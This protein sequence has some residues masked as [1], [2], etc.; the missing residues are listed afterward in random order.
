M[1][2]ATVKSKPVMVVGVVR[3]RAQDV[4]SIT[5]EWD[6]DPAQEG[7]VPTIDGSELLTDGKRHPGTSRTQNWVKIGKKQD[8]QKHAYGITILKGTGIGSVTV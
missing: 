6:L 8:G 5:I 2:Q 1:G 3:V 4:N 7:Y